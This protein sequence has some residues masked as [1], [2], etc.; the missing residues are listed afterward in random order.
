MG[1]NGV[2]VTLSK[3]NPHIHDNKGKKRARYLPTFATGCIF[4]MQA[5]TTVRYW[6]LVLVYMHAPLHQPEG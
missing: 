6:L 5:K 2:D 3:V 4:S 1:T